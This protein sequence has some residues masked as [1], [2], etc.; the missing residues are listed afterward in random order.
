MGAAYQDFIDTG[1][2]TSLTTI[3]ELA[4]LRSSAMNCTPIFFT[5]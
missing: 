1:V 3:F 5:K 2:S 4:R